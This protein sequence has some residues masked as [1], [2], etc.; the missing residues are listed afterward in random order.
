LRLCDILS[1]YTIY[2]IIS[3][4]GHRDYQNPGALYRGLDNLRAGEY[5]IGGARGIDA[6]ALT[7]LSRT[8]PGSIRTVV[9]PNRLIDQPV[10]AQRVIKLHAT[11]VIELK[12][13]GADRYQLRNKYMVDNSN[14][15]RAFYDFRKTGGTYNTIKYA[16]S[17]GKSHSVWPM[18]K[19]NTQEIMRKSPKE[20]SAWLKKMRDLK[21][22]LRAIKGI[23]IEWLSQATRMLMS[24]LQAQAFQEIEFAKWVERQE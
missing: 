23:V 7:Y 20:M 9:V 6:E 1:D 13:T 17:K 16:E 22:P 8:Q 12:N 18:N 5:L 19:I 3:I 15:T 21:V 14:H 2:D 4:T 10:E 24:N 11:R